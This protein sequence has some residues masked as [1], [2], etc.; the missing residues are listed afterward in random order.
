MRRSTRRGIL[1]CAQNIVG[2]IVAS[3]IVTYCA[4]LYFKSNILT[5]VQRATTILRL[6]EV[7]TDLDALTRIDGPLTSQPTSIE[8]SLPR[9]VSEYRQQLA[10]VQKQAEAQLKYLDQLIHWY[11][12]LS[13][14][15]P[16]RYRLDRVPD[17][18]SK[19]KEDLLQLR[20]RLEGFHN[21]LM[22]LHTE[23]GDVLAA[24]GLDSENL[25]RECAHNQE[26]LQRK[27]DTLLNEMTDD[28]VVIRHKIWNRVEV[29]E[30]VLR[31][32]EPRK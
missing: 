24:G 9:A 3:L 29:M 13:V 7:I 1:S 28:I 8:R 30:E 11:D 6:D 26:L 27:C 25:A 15:Q 23:M 21:A 32:W 12:G 18:K 20:S 19:F 16:G 22:A 10:T 14:A 5:V 2:G 4:Y 31:E 17:P